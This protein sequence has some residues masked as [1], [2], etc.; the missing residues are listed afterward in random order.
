MEQKIFYKFKNIDKYTLGSLS[1]KYF[2]FSIP[3]QLNDP[4]DC[5]IPVIEDS[6]DENIIKW[7][8]HVKA[9]SDNLGYD[10]KI[11]NN[12]TPD[13]FRH[14]VS[15]GLLNLVG[16]AEKTN[17]N[18]HILSL[19][20][21]NTTINMWK[22]KDYCKNF[23]G[24]CI[25]YKAVKLQDERPFYYIPINNH[26]PMRT[27]EIPAKVKLPFFILKKIEYDNDRNHKYNMF[28]QNYSDDYV[29]QIQSPIQNE[30]IMYNLFHKTEKWN[31]EREYRG[32]YFNPSDND[33]SRVYYPDEIVESITFGKNCPSSARKQIYEIMKTYSNFN[34]IAFYEARPGW[35]NLKA[36]IHPI[37]KN[38]LA[39]LP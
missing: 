3:E 1:E 37:D 12:L 25:E 21:C 18:F 13:Y 23:S 31:K 27:I 39:T 28:E 2:Y 10:I 19:T 24:V 9:L 38:Y 8:K 35:K 7:I 4:E 17:K 15:S 5:K 16:A 32:F 11:F 36:A 34:E 6:S 22:H 29:Q 26:N 14:L 20:D 33:D 30:I